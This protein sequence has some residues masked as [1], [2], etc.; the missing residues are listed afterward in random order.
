MRTF[1]YTFIM[2]IGVVKFSST[3]EPNELKSITLREKGK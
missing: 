2:K 1:T 3:N